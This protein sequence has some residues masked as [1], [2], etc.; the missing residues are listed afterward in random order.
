MAHYHFVFTGLC[1]PEMWLALTLSADIIACHSTKG[2]HPE[3]G[4]IRETSWCVNIKEY[5]YANLG[6]IA[7]YIPRFTA[8]IYNELPISP[9]IE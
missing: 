2:R 9:K 8:Q 5:S 7:Y 6:D 3:K 1:A 4:V